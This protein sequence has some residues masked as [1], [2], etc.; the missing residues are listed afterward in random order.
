MT[1]FIW[2]T[3]KICITTRSV[4]AL[5]LLLFNLLF[6]IALIFYAV[7]NFWFNKRVW[8]IFECFVASVPIQSWLFAMQYFKS[9]LYTC[10]GAD[11]VKYKIHSVV[12]YTVIFSYATVLIYFRSREHT[13]LEKLY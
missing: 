1:L 12:K 2:V 7:V 5:T 9:Y 6:A 10:A 4:F 8:I 13:A 3:I 11:S